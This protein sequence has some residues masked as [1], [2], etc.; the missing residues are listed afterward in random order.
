MAAALSIAPDALLRSS[1]EVLEAL[2]AITDRQRT[3]ALWALEVQALSA[4]MTH[5]LW[6]LTVR[7][8]S[9]PGAHQP[10]P[11]RI[12]RPWQAKAPVARG[13]RVSLGEF[14]ERMTGKG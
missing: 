4:E 12:P 8:N 1:D 11:L 3:E 10:E 7:V 13:R 5:A 9:K 14:V 6:R 2:V